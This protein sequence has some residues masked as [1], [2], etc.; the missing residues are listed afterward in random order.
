MSN[1]AATRVD[2]LAELAGDCQEIY[3]GRAR[4]ALDDT[5]PCPRYALITSEGSAESSYTDNP[6]LTVHDTPEAMGA[7]AAAEYVDGW[8]VRSMHDLETGDELDCTVTVE[9]ITNVQPLASRARC[10]RS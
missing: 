6:N 9:V 5:V 10:S 2:R 1:T 8:C 7:A 3:D 4:A